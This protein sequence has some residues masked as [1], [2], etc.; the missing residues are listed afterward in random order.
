MANKQAESIRRE[1]S[2]TFRKMGENEQITIKCIATLKQ[3]YLQN[4]IVVWQGWK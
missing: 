3:N 1:Y 2:D 4:R